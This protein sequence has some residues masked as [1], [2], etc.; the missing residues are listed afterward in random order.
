MKKSLTTLSLLAL[1][2]ASF[3]SP[4]KADIVYVTVTGTVVNF[5]NNQVNEHFDVD[6]LF[7]S[8]GA[9]LLG[10]AY[11]AQFEFD[12]SL[13]QTYSSATE[14][15]AYG[16]LDYSAITSPS[17]AASL[18]I[19]GQTVSLAGGY[20]GEIYGAT[21]AV[22]GEATSLAYAQASVSEYLWNE[23]E[24]DPG[25]SPGS[26]TAPFTIYAS[27]NTYSQGFFEDGNDQ[28]ALAP[29]VYTESLTNPVP[30]PTSMALLGIG[31]LGICVIARRRR[32]ALT[33]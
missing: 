26:I 8:A 7:G 24:G 15:F 13:G 1:C 33:Y 32:P 29:T 21:A 31:L 9:S 27:D 11:T 3:A 16:G 6:G 4:A 5:V 25:T 2:A 19:N 20:D 18:T 22:Y 30:E 12:T 10:D 28:L 14:N 17:I 23:M